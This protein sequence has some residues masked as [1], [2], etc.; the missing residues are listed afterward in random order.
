MSVKKNA[1]SLWISGG[2][3][4]TTAAVLMS[5]SALNT[6]DEVETSERPEKEEVNNDQKQESSK[7]QSKEE[8]IKEQEDKDVQKVTEEIAKQEQQAQIIIDEGMPFAERVHQNMYIVQKGDTLSAISKATGV[9]VDELQRINGIAD[10]N[11]INPGWRLAITEEVI[12]M[13]KEEGSFPNLA[14][15]DGNDKDGRYDYTMPEKVEVVEAVDQPAT[16][17]EKEETPAPKPSEEKKEEVVK[18]ETPPVI[19]ESPGKPEEEVTTPEAP[20]EDETPATPEKDDKPVLS[21]DLID[22]VEIDEESKVIDSSEETIVAEGTGSSNVLE[23]IEES[24]GETT[25]TSE[26]IYA[27]QEVVD[28]GIDPIGEQV[29]DMPIVIDELVEQSIVNTVNTIIPAEY[30]INDEGEEV[31]VTPEKSSKTVTSH[32]SY[33]ILPG[34][35]VRHDEHMPFGQMR[36]E[37]GINGTLI[38]VIESNF[39]D[40]ELIDEKVVDTIRTEPTN[41]IQYVGTAKE[42]VFVEHERVNTTMI[43]KHGRIV[44][45]NPEL[46]VGETQTVQEGKDGEYVKLVVNVLHNGSFYEVFSTDANTVYAVPEIIEVGTMP[47]GN[48][49]IRRTDTIQQ[50]VRIEAPQEVTYEETADLYEGEYKVKQLA[51]DGVRTIITEVVY[52]NNGEVSSNITSDNV[53]EDA[54]EAIVLVG[55]KNASETIMETSQ[56]EYD[57]DPIIEYSADLHEGEEFVKQEGKSGLKNIITE[58]EYFKGQE[59][60]RTVISET[61]QSEASP[62]IIVKGT[63]PNVEVS[64]KQITETVSTPAPVNPVIKYSDEYIVGTEIISQEATEGLVDVVV[65]ITY[66]DG[67]EVSRVVVSETIVEE[68]LPQVITKGTREAVVDVSSETTN[69]VIAQPDTIIRETNELYVGE[70]RVVQEGAEGLKEVVTTTTTI[71]GVVDSIDKVETIIKDAQPRIVEVGVEDKV[72]TKENKVL[73]TIEQPDTIRRHT[74]KLSKG[75]ERIVQSGKAGSKEVITTITYTNGVET[76][77]DVIENTISQATPEIIEVGTAA[78]VTKETVSETIT[79]DMGE[80]LTYNPYLYEKSRIVHHAG[81]QEIVEA[82]Y[83]ITYSDGVEVGRTLVEEIVI[84]R[85]I[86]AHIE[87][88]TQKHAELSDL[89]YTEMTEEEAYEEALSNEQQFEY[90]EWISKDGRND[91]WSGTVVRQ[92]SEDDRQAFNNGTIIDETVLNQHLLELVN[93]ERMLYGVEELNLD[94]SLKQGT[95]ARANELAEEGTIRPVDPITGEAPTDAHGN[96]LTHHRPMNENGEYEDFDTAFEYR[97]ENPEG[98]VGENLAIR[99]YTGNPYRL[100]SEKYLAQMFFKQWYDSP[101]HYQNMIHAMYKG[102]WVSVQVGSEANFG[103]MSTAGITNSV[104]AVQILSVD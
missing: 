35:E 85:G 47:S 10:A 60:S 39:V 76:N 92:I 99:N 63:T 16:P 11:K 100:F 53:T 6:T 14:K 7:K 91:E 75:E 51:R 32:N 15:Q 8:V 36:V 61:V 69:E 57:V 5:M 74:D 90:R 103:D 4:A 12:Q 64:S 72:E 56:K 31:L 48:D 54:R 3:V 79:K 24:E 71:D 59:V 73:V 28:D 102:T 41:T 49:I 19:D 50:H 29:T 20:A 27:N 43:L 67:E 66:H 26:I 52:E 93:N 77:R 23:I 80:K 25:T 40:G 81:Q 98:S 38:N 101:G 87:Q 30:D 1:K 58:I 70:E 65:E 44:R 37:E 86:V 104:V 62:K 46:A 89:I 97:S 13:V 33:T 45:E 9:P 82:V 22:E 96:P 95:H 17:N 88:G 78:I 94:Y 68:A 83:E 21:E 42:S 34:V 2:V 84:Q 18:P 55:T